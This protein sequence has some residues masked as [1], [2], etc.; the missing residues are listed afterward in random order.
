MSAEQL[1]MMLNKQCGGPLAM[2]KTKVKE[3]GKKQVMKVLEKLPSKDDIKEK[4]ISA[5][6]SIPAQRKMKRVYNTIHG[7]ISKLENILLRAK[8]KLDD[9]NAKINK[10]TQGVM[11]D[12]QTIMA[13]LAGIILVVKI[14]IQ[15]TPALLALSTGLA[16]N[17]GLINRLG[18]AILKAITIVGIYG[19]TITSIDAQIKKHV[20]QTLSLS[21]LFM[22]EKDLVYSK[23]KLQEVLK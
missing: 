20:N 23:M 7:L 12:I 2:A 1:T 4:L 22:L 19:S 8:G 16:A 13:I 5:A 10:V 15:I 14:I 18:A 17:G 9:L 21:F 11:P 3:E 6:C